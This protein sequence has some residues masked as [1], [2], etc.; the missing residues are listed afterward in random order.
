MITSGIR[1]GSPAATTRGF[2][3]EEFQKVGQLILRVLE[4]LS[5]NGAENNQ[6]IE[7]SVKMEVIELCKGFPIY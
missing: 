4:G 6:E 7:Q 2:G 1:L 5:N 3:T